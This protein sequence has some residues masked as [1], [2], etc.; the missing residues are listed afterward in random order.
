MN[1]KPITTVTNSLMATAKPLGLGALLT[2]GVVN[3]VAAAG[4]Q[5]GPAGPVPVTTLIQDPNVPFQYALGVEKFRDKC[6]ACHGQWAE[7]VA[8]K[9]PPLVHRYYRPGHH[10][11]AAFY[12]AAMNGVRSH[13]WNFG[14]MPPVAG[15]TKQ[16]VA[17]IVAF[18]RWWQEQ[19]GIQ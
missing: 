18:I 4:M 17:A 3:G 15:I 7:G 13:H 10:P 19:N 6:A 2:V 5:H 8:D 16:D 12:Q 11:D 1:S 9:G 14:D